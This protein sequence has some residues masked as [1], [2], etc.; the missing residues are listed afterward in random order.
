MAWR[1]GDVVVRRD[2]WDGKLWYASAAIVVEDS[3]RRRV[4]Y[5]PPG[6]QAVVPANPVETFFEELRDGRWRLEKT[7]RYNHSLVIARPEKLHS[8]GLFWDDDWNFLSWYVNLEE[9][10]RRSDFGF[11]T[12]DLILDVVV[13][14]DRSDWKWKDEDQLALAMNLGLVNTVKAGTLREEGRRVA[15]DAM[16]GNTPFNEGWERWRPP[17]GW[18]PPRLPRAIAGKVRGG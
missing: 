11:D 4:L 3:P 1:Q 14:P 18:K 17:A 15:T 16:R 8:V 2:L 5:S 9:P 10:W 13:A 7:V 12:C 6:S